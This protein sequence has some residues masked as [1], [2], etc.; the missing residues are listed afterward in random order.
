[1][2][3]LASLVTGRVRKKKRGVKEK[4]IDTVQSYTE[5]ETYI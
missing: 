4:F 2:K 5:M 1:M 3:N